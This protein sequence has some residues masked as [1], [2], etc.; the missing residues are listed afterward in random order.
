MVAKQ[1]ARRPGS[2]WIPM[3]H[4]TAH[5]KSSTFLPYDFSKNSQHIPPL[6]ARPLPS[7]GP[8]STIKTH[9]SRDHRE[10]NQLSTSD[11]VF[12]VQRFR[13]YLPWFCF[14][15]INKNHS[16]PSFSIYV[17]V[18]GKRNRKEKPQD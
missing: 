13:S 2:H 17:T 18:S 6:D 4:G 9:V 10:T 7:I 1:G 12:N 8:H 15:P 11:Q 14:F 3:H 5:C 16:R